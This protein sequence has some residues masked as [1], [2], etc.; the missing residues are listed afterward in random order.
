MSAY[1]VTSGSQTLFAFA[2]R[3]EAMSWGQH[4]ADRAEIG[5]TGATVHYLIQEWQATNYDDVFTAAHIYGRSSADIAYRYYDSA[6]IEEVARSRDEALEMNEAFDAY[7]VMLAGVATDCTLSL[8]ALY[9]RGM[10][11]EAELAQNIIDAGVR[12]SRELRNINL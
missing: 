11:T 9:T 3:E 5:N 4:Y 8:T 6:M 10:I 7:R 2:T 1:T 12:L